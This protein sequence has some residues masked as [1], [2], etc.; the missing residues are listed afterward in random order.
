MDYDTNVPNMLVNIC[1]AVILLDM[2][3]ITAIRISIIQ[4]SL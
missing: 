1:I 3:K 4:R 2:S